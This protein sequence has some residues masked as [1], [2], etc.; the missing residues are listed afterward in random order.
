MVP[1]SEALFQFIWRHSL[2]RPEGLCTTSG[3]LVTVIFPGRY[4]TDAG[5]DFEAAKIR[6]ANTMLVGNVELHLNSGDWFR[7]GHQHDARYANIILH[8]VACNDPGA[9]CP[10]HIPV[11]ELGPQIPD[12]IGINYAWLQQNLQRIPCA[13][14]LHRVKD[15]ARTAWLH[16][17]IAER[18]E[19]KFEDW[20][21]KLQHSSGDWRVLLYHTLA[22]N[23]GFKVN[24]DAFLALA[25]S[26]PLNLLSRHRE[27]LF[28]LEALL[29][30]QAGLLA[31]RQDEAYPYR[32]QQEYRH[33]RLKYKLVP[34][35]AERWKFLRMRPANFP[36][37]RI[38]QFAA[39]IH[40]SLH[41]FDQVVSSESL[42]ALETLFEVTA[43]P[44]WDNHV[45]FGEQQQK[46]LPKQLGRDSIRN[47]ITNT[48]APLRF[49]YS[50]RSGLGDHCETAVEL[51]E[52]LPPEH[53]AILEEWRQC[54]W[55]AENA[56]QAQSLIQLF[57]H[58]CCARQCLQCSIG[59]TLVRSG[60]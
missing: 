12:H 2:Y 59:H 24:S 53:N 36:T 4:N 17:L 40:G 32:L 5:P 9:V 39:L 51:L 26:L 23:F 20:E 46:L 8:V 7:H 1:D 3:E 60:P 45:R 30:G 41:L 16:R 28:R 27:D 54:G 56:L 57:N 38:A 25:Q 47:I 58:Y 19:M 35:A 6:I 22:A 13:P 14:Q 37:V 52:Q 11:L 21:Q 33:L 50:G 55:V 31:G 48:V 18:W 42:I 49:F 10:P 15:I 44:Y 29:F 43:S 34:L